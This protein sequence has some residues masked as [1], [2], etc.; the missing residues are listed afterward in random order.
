[1]QLNRYDMA[2]IEQALREAINQGADYHKIST[3][4]AVLGKL[5]EAHGAA[6]ASR[7]TMER[8]DG[9]RYDTDDSSDLRA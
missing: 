6:A 9:F 1:M 7:T 5:N 3:Y 8:N 2:V 4:Q